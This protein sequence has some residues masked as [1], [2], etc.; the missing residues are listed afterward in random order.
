MLFSRLR[1]IEFLSLFAS[2][3]AFCIAFIIMVM[4]GEL[5]KIYK[6]AIESTETDDDGEDTLDLSVKYLA[7]GVYYLISAA[8]TE[9]LLIF[10]FLRRYRVY[11]AAA[12]R[13]LASGKISGQNRN[14]AQNGNLEQAEATEASHS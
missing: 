2:F 4:F 14:V 11:I 3:D 9:N 8:A 10:L 5:Q 13:S 6:E 12:D 1:T 7:P